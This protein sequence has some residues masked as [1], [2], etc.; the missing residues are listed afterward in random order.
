MNYLTHKPST[1]G[2]LKTLNKLIYS[3]TQLLHLDLFH[4]SPQFCWEASSVW[5]AGFESANQVT[6]KISIFLTTY[7]LLITHPVF[8]AL[9]RI[10]FACAH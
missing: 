3:I 4:T 5:T 6:F 1:Q 2:G 7:L 10:I 8:Q 9:H